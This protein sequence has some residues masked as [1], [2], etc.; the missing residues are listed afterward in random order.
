[1][2]IPEEVPVMTLPDATLFPQSLLPLYI[3]EPR[4]R[5]MLADALESHRMFSVAFQKPGRKRE[6]PSLVAGLGFIRAAV[7]HADGTSHLVLQGLARVEL[8]ERRRT[9]PYR[10]HRIKT[11]A[12]PPCDGVRADALAAK[13]R[14]LIQERIASGLS[15]PFPPV[16]PPNE[17]GAEPIFS[18]SK[19]LGYLDSL[20]GPDQ[21]ADAVSG[22]FLPGAIDRQHILETVD[23]EARL[24]RLIRLLL[25]AGRP[26]GRHSGD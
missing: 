13:V 18:A 8:G 17:P 21:L 26:P 19:I 5:R 11:L 1:M 24:R 9:R 4:Y 22:A 23:V 3:F 16:M 25:A 2:R 6:T 10:V 12:T 7:S 15:L 14:E 20:P